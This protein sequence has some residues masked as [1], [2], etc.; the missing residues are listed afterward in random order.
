MIGMLRFEQITD[1][2]FEAVLGAIYRD[3][4]SAAAQVAADADGDLAAL[5]DTA[6]SIDDLLAQNDDAPWCG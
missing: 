2:A 3:S 5:A 6:A 1:P 4:A